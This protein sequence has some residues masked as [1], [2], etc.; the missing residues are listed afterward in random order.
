LK[1]NILIT[2]GSGY[3]GIHLIYYLFKLNKYNIIVLDKKP[4]SFIIK[5]KI[6]FFKANLINFKK[7]NSILKRVSPCMV[8]HLAGLAHIRDSFK[9]RKKYWLNNVISSLNLL[10]AMK[11]NNYKQIIFS[12]SCLVYGES[13]LKPEGSKN[14]KGLSPYAENKIYIE[15][16]ILEYGKKFKFNYCILRFFNIAGVF[17]GP[18]KIGFSRK[19]GQRIIPII[20]KAIRN[21]KK[22]FING[23][24]HKTVDGTCVRDFVHPVDIA[25]FIEK[26]IINFNNKTF[27]EIINLGSGRGYS[28][29][30]LIKL[31]SKKMLKKKLKIKI[32]KGRKGDTPISIANI[33][34]AKNKFNWSTKNSNIKYII[35]STYEWIKKN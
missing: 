10:K 22:I 20:L 4:H 8:I 17:G 11:N 1:K 35:S 16:K 27:K 33:D 18:E 34:K 30:E 21:N 3:I 24:N 9:N 14:L 13:S 2:G 26:L 32:N 31:C 23:N 29:M 12:S 25:V 28:I 19:S 6:K 5:K 15:K 7:L